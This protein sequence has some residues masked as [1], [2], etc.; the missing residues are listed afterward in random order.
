MV[1]QYQNW[2]MPFAGTLDTKTDHKVLEPPN[3][4]VLSNW[5]FSKRG[6]LQL[7]RGFTQIPITIA[8]T[9]PNVV[10]QGTTITAGEGIATLGDELLVFDGTLMYSWDIHHQNWVPKGYVKPLAIQ[11]RTFVVEGGGRYF[12]STV[13][14]ATNGSAYAIHAYADYDAPAVDERITVAVEDITTGNIVLRQKIE[15]GFASTNSPGLRICTSDSGTIAYIVA[16]NTTMPDRLVVHTFNVNTFVATSV[17]TFNN[18]YSNGSFDICP[19][20]NASGIYIAFASGSPGPY[21]IEVNRLNSA[22]VVLASASTPVP[23]APSIGISASAF[24]VWIVYG[25]SVGGTSV[26]IRTPQ[27]LTALNAPVQISALNLIPVISATTLGAQEAMIVGSGYDRIDVRYDTGQ[28]G[29]ILAVTSQI[30]PDAAVTGVTLGRAYLETKIFDRKIVVCWSNID[31]YY[32]NL[33][34]FALDSS[35]FVFTLD[36]AF[37]TAANSVCGRFHMGS[38]FPAF[39]SD[40]HSIADVGIDSVTVLGQRRAHVCMSEFAPAIQTLVRTTIS[41]ASTTIV[42][43][44]SP[45][46]VMTATAGENLMINAGIPYEYDGIDVVEQGFHYFPSIVL[47]SSTSS[48]GGFLSNGAYAWRFTYAWIDAHGGIHESAP[49]PVFIRTLSAGTATQSILMR[50]SPYY[51]TQKRNVLINMYRTDAGGSLF[52]FVTQVANDPNVTEMVITDT[53]FPLQLQLPLYTDSGEL[54]NTPL[55]S[56]D[57]L[58]SAKGRLFAIVNKQYVAYSKEL[59]PGTEF[60]PIEFSDFLVTTVG[61]DTSDL[62]ALGEMDGNVIVF[63]AQ[64][65]NVISGDGP[66][67]LGQG[68]FPRP[69]RIATD[70]GCSDAFSVVRIPSGILFKNRRGI[71]LLDRG[72]TTSKQAGEPVT[73]FDT[74]VIS[75]A[76]LIGNKTQVQFIS[77]RASTNS[78]GSYFYDYIENRWCEVFS[79]IVTLAWLAGTSWKDRYTVI[80]TIGR[81]FVEGDTCVDYTLN[82]PL[83]EA[84]IGNLRTSWIKLQ[85]IQGFQRIRRIGVVGDEQLGTI[86]PAQIGFMLVAYDYNTSPIENFPLFSTGNLNFQSRNKLGRAKCEAIAVSITIQDPDVAT[87][88]TTGAS[89]QGLTLEIGAEPGIYRRFG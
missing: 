43:S 9:N 15:A 70:A 34:S 53:G 76:C 29:N 58:I 45:S 16:P 69:S 11:S 72:F 54:T 62:T 78:V 27:T 37:A 55:P 68:A 84:V 75:S 7:R 83:T 86:P 40:G 2:S 63:K 56:A 13:C 50:V 3:F 22:G 25:A 32:N 31:V 51:I 57:A 26:A 60:E 14:H 4:E 67:A 38:A 33:P 81:V 17:Q 66:N 12:G 35:R 46:R 87:G 52:Y 42:T 48:T 47:L 21:T 82:P 89:L 41:M 79:G 10:V 5:E 88:I 61:T 8:N 49:S 59:I 85:G 18:S 1:M 71:Y 19:C 20:E 44:G 30:M 64:S 23:A 80:D 74:Y 28:P 73:N 36:G 65:I 6:S 77:A 24:G 39:G